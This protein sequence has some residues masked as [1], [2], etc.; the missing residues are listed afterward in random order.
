MLSLK[1]TF[2]M[3]TNKLFWPVHLLHKCPMMC[4]CWAWLV[5]LAC[6]LV[7]SLPLSASH[8]TVKKTTFEKTKHNLPLLPCQCRTIHRRSL[9]R[10]IGARQKKPDSRASSTA[11]TSTSSTA[12]LRSSRP[13]GGNTSPTVNQR[14]SA[15]TSATL[16]PRGR[17]NPNTPEQD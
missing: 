2:Q 8:V 6:L 15:T 1:S 3:L 16:P 12:P 14:T 13:S 9:P 4:I 17:S 10:S 7:H 5:R 11:A